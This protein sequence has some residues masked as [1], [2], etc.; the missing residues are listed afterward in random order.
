MTSQLFTEWL[1]ILDKLLFC[2][3]KKIIFIDNYLAN[4]IDIKLISGK[5]MLLLANIVSATKHYVNLKFQNASLKV[6]SSN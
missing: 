5:L 3:R 6:C 2:K 4:S 1:L